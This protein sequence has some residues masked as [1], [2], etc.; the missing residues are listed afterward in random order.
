M[1]IT[2]NY[3]NLKEWAKGKL[4][5]TAEANN[6]FQQEV[7]LAKVETVYDL[8]KTLLYN[9]NFTLEELIYL[10]PNNF[11]LQ[12]IPP[13]ILGKERWNVTQDYLEF[14]DWVRHIPSDQINKEMKIRY[15]FLTRMVGEYM[16]RK[17]SNDDWQIQMSPFPA[18][19]KGEETSLA[20]LAIIDKG[21]V[22]NANKVN[23]HGNNLSQVVF[24]CGIQY[25]SRSGRVSIHT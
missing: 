7:A 3:D 17:R 12:N 4:E 16:A 22:Y 5:C 10:L 6:R 23:W 8:L 11:R 9:E 24:N 13:S 19:C 1:E 14:Y 2:V 21:K 25:D 18:M 15:F 20:Y